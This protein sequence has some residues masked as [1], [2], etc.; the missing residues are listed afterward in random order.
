MTAR[1]ILKHIEKNDFDAFQSDWLNLKE[2]LTEKEKQKLLTEILDDHYSEKNFSFFIKV[3]D[4]IIDTKISLDFSIDHW[5]PTLLS[6]VAHK[7]SRQLFDYFLR[8]GATL[9]FIGDR[10]AFET[11]ETIKREVGADLTYRFSTCL[12]YALLKLGDTLTVYYSYSVPET[13]EY[14]TS[15]QDINENEEITIKKQDYYYLIEQSQYLHDLIHTDRLV[16]HIKLL[17]G[18]TYVQMANK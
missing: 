1:Q 8:K 17:G 3:F 15:W 4:K 5:A 7:A 2:T 9:N 18:K 11:E 13:K 16:D 6:L 12:D 10:Y 14:V